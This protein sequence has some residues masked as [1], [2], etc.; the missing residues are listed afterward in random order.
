M[1]GV[2]LVEKFKSFIRDLMVHKEE[3]SGCLCSPV[4]CR[5]FGD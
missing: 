1:E 5:R 4:G 3:A 2:G